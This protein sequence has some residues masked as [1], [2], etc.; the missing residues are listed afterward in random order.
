MR[1][2]ET[3]IMIKNVAFISALAP[4]IL[5][6]CGLSLTVLLDQYLK[7]DSRDHMI[8]IIVLCF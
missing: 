1:T 8:A 2:G 4:L 7:K 3:K 6:L 5:L